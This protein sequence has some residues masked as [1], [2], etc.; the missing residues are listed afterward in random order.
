ME[1]FVALLLLVSALPLA[2]R[3]DDYGPR[4]DIAAIRHDLP[5]IERQAEMY[6][7]VVRSVAIDSVIV[8]EGDALA[9]WHDTGTDERAIARLNYKYGRWWL[10]QSTSFGDRG[11]LLAHC[12]PDSAPTP[13]FL[14]KA[15]V[16]PTLAALA[17]EH[18]PIVQEA[19]ALVSQ[20]ANDDPHYKIC[21]EVFH[22]DR[23]YSP[24]VLPF[25]T[26]GRRLIEGDQYHVMVQLAKNDADQEASI[27]GPQ[28]R[29]PTEAESW[30]NPPGGN[31]YFF[32]SGTVHATKP[33]HVQAGTT[34]DVW[35]PFVLDPSL[36][37]SLTIAAPNAM[38]LGPVE[39]TLTNNTL[40]FV[41][42]AF[43]APPGAELMGEIDS[44]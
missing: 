31:A 25:Q 3:A 34:I 39:G 9:Q 23:E 35:F 33:V 6:P 19:T 17:G 42:P 40:H 26:V 16:N 11:Y 28:S 38:S 2:A 29:A 8:D 30:A 4:R 18:M 37:Y 32:F 12:P 1:R 7:G 41:L 20:Y 5:I 24:E 14:I 43:T 22:I 36:R 21:S 13:Q 10:L 44:D 15:G 27:I